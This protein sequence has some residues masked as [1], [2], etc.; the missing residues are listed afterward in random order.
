V[1]IE[2]EARVTHQLHGLEA[3]FRDVKSELCEVK[4]Y[5]DEVKLEVSDHGVLLKSLRDMLQ[6][7]LDR[8]PS[9]N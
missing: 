7:V 3:E 5:L 8:L 9:K 1:T 2:L 4:D 6:E